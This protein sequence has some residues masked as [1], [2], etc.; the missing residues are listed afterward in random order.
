V[1]QS[2]LGIAK[3]VVILVLIPILGFFFLKDGAVLRRMWIDEFV[4][5]EKRPII[6]SI[7]KD[8]HELMGQFMRALVMLSLAT[9][10]VYSAFLTIIGIPY[11]LLLALLAAMLE[12]IPVIGTATAAILII[13]VAAA[14]GNHVVLVIVF[15]AAYRLFQDYVLQPQLMSHGVALHPLAVIFGVLAGEQIAGV[16][17]MFF[18]IPAMAILRV[19][20]LR[21]QRDRVAASPVTTP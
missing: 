3:N 1:G 16:P 18:S 5:P 4:S 14:T 20:Y 21:M 19:V 9:F 12:F 10:T 6:E 2:A 15:M 7:V 17:G 8:V 13:V 11:G